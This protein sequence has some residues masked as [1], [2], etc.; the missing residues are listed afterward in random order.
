MCPGKQL[1]EDS[2]WLTVAQFLATL[3]VSLPEGSKPPP[4]QYGSGGSLWVLS[5][6]VWIGK[7]DELYRRHLARFKAKIRAR[8][9]AAVELIECALGE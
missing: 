1:S 7:T 5:V 8:S 9:A 3:T 2:L 6:L 4:V